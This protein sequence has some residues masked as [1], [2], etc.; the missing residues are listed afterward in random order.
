MS[1]GNEVDNIPPAVSASVTS[2]AETVTLTSTQLRTLIENSVATALRSINDEGA[3]TSAGCGS[4]ETPT[5]VSPFSSS[6]SVSHIAFRAPQPLFNQNPAVWFEILEQQF[7]VSNIVAEK[8]KYSHAVG[9]LDS[10]LH[11]LFADLIIRDKGSMPYTVFKNAIIKGLEESE[12]TKINNLIHG[13]VLGDLKPS[14][15]L[16]KF[17][18]NAGCN[19][20]E[21]SIKQLWLK[22]LPQ[23]V[24]MI[25][26]PF[27][28]DFPLS[29]LAERADNV[30]E[31]MVGIRIDSIEK[32]A[33]QIVNSNPDITDLLEKFKKQIFTEIAE[34]SNHRTRTP[35]R[36][37]SRNR[38]FRSTS[39]GDE[40]F[41]HRR[42]G[43]KAN[44]CLPFCKHFGKSA[45]ETNSKNT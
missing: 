20:N 21:Q 15:L 43:N 6:G 5:T 1:P 25:L 40:C 39:R 33:S 22:R 12:K 44:K 41:Y 34:F 36:S 19:F 45:P 30:M 23:Q 26:T 8:T 11:D 35:V 16:A 3:S 24:Q 27:E 42:F 29:T 7:L 38:R 32:P 13:L 31:T 37:N 18:L 9:A 4:T 2:T 28:N 17:R 10:R 14:Q